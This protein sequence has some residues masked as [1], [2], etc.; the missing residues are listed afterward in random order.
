MTFPASMSL[1]SLNGDNGFNVTGI[2]NNDL[3]GSSISSGDIN[4]DGIV[5]LLIGAYGVPAGVYQG[6]GYVVFG[7][8]RSLVS[9]ISLGNLNGTNGFKM[10]GVSNNDYA[11]DSISAGDINGDGIGD[12]LIGAYGAPAGVMQGAVYVVFG[13]RQPFV[14][15]LSLGSLTG[16][17]GFTVTGMSGDEAGDA[18]SSGDINGDG[19]SDLLIGAPEAPSGTGQGATYVVF[20][21]RQPF[22]PSFSLGSLTGN[23]GFKITG[24]SGDSAGSSISSGDINGDGIADVL[25]GA[26][27]ASRGTSQGA[28]YVVF[29]S[30]HAFSAS[31]SFR[32]L[33]GTSGFNVTGINN[34]YYTGYSISCRGHQR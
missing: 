13:S 16:V 21:S 27:S 8:R 20:G 10:S 31:F 1:L 19:I 5:D 29:G 9:S 2:N 7:S 3:A 4:G 28:A 33:N 17:N 11:G 12:V 24:S 30:R 22:A 15:N 26:Q 6:A 23:N 14:A 25:V 18:I 34:N 32:S